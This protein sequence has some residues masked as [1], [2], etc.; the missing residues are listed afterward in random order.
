M[1]EDK[2]E[3]IYHCEGCSAVL[4]VSIGATWLYAKLKCERCGRVKTWRPEVPQDNRASMA[5]A[6]V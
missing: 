2:K 3:F 5:S 4:Y 6:G 1:P